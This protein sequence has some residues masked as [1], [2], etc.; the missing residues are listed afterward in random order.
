MNIPA[1]EISILGRVGRKTAFTLQEVLTTLAIIGI[2]GAIAIPAASFYYGKCC[3][4][5]AVSEIT[6]MIRE[7]KQNALCNDSYY[8]IAFDPV[9][10]KVS[11]LSGKGPDG[12]WNTVDDEVVRSFAL[13]AKGGGLRF[14]YGNYGPRPGHAADPDGI[15]F[16]N[17]N[18]LVCNPNLTGTSGT[19]YLISRSGYAMAITMNT[20]DYGYSLWTWG[21]GKWSQL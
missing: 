15:T 12:R 1:F 21:N 10:G 16:Q 11:L 19:V 18:T 14:G 2:I 6:G 8:A 4:M 20:A 17:N 9:L 7:A 5:A 13:A 3:V